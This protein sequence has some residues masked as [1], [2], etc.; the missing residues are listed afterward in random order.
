MLIVRYGG[1][2]AVAVRP[3]R[4][5]LESVVRESHTEAAPRLL[6]K[7][8]LLPVLEVL[9]LRGVDGVSE[10]VGA[11]HVGRE[12]G[13]RGGGKRTEGGGEM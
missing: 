4:H 3:V 7:T 6:P 1:R 9:V 11:L 2:V 12:E 13:V 10:G 8:R 5:R